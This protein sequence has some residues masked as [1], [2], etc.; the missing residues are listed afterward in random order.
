MV[1]ATLLATTVMSGTPAQAG[2]RW[3]ASFRQ[4]HSVNG[5]PTTSWLISDGNARAVRRSS[6][7]PKISP[8]SRRA[9]ESWRGARH[10]FSAFKI[11]RRGKWNTAT[12]TISDGVKGKHP[13]MKGA[14]PRD[15]SVLCVDE[16]QIGL[17][18]LAPHG[19]S[20]LSGFRLPNWP[21]PGAHGPKVARMAV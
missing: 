1:A 18:P 19:A 2:E 20:S 13:K 9:F 4:C 16:F 17:R 8:T 15:H 11:A 14:G 3:E 5:F 12:K 10:S 21:S 6:S 7:N